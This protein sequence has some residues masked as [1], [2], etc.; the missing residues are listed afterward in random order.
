MMDNTYGNKSKEGESIKE[1]SSDEKELFQTC[2]SKIIFFFVIVFVINLIITYFL[3]KSADRKL[4]EYEHQQEIKSYINI[5]PKINDLESTTNKKDFFESKTL[6][7]NEQNVTNFYIHYIRP[8][9]VEEEEKYNQIL[10]KNILYDDYPNEKKLGQLSVYD[11]YRLV[12]KKNLIQINKINPFPEPKISIIIPVTSTKPNLIRSFNSIQTQTFKDI[13]IIISDDCSE[14]NEDL[15]KYLLQNEPRLRI[16]T[17]T[18][19]MGLWRTRMD[20]FLYSKGK[21]ILHFDPGDILSDNFVLEDMFRFVTKYNLDTVRFSFSKITSENIED[22]LENMKIYPTRHL[23]IIYGRPDY[24]PREDG[25]GT[26]CNRLVR[27]NVITKGFD[28][29]DIDLLN[30]NKNIWED[31]WWNELIDRVSFSNLIV[32]KLG[33][34]SFLDRNTITEENIK[35]TYEKDR[36]IR[37]FIYNWYLDYELLPK[38]IPKNETMDTLRNYSQVN[39]TYNG[40]PINLGYVSTYFGAYRHFLNILFK[41]PFIPDEEKNLIKI[42]YNKVPKTKNK[43]KKN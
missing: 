18:K 4:A 32:N 27:A 26:I 16:F 34:I 6:S 22:K 41:D 9:T 43:M 28:L 23:K 20:G 29:V 10:Y 12:N 19:K 1:N 38:D 25:Y 2:F 42:L 37:E 5:F 35:S 14:N 11:F 33:Y 17:H 8:L 36:T 31:K 21:Y 39:N 7:I 13:E 40:V 15:F 24:N 3:K 30:A